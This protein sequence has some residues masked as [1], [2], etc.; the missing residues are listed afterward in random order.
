MADEVITPANFVMPATQG[1]VTQVTA[2]AAGID[3]GDILYKLAGK[4][5]QGDAVT[6]AKA[7][8]SVMALTD[9]GLDDIIL[10]LHLDN[11]ITFAPGMAGLTVGESLML[12]AT[13]NGGK[14]TAEADLISGDF[15]T[16]IFR[17]I[18]STT[19]KTNLVATGK[20]K[21]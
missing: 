2:G 16:E 3:F 15:I 20:A 1:I 6:V 10:V 17:A 19:V 21:P 8:V 4:W 5:L 13:A 12:S 14:V 9:G 11:E 7:D 18:T